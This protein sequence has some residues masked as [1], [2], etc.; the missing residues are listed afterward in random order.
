M[1]GREQKRLETALRKLQDDGIIGRKG[2]PGWGYADRHSEEELK[3]GNRMRAGWFQLWR[4]W[5]VIIPVPDDLYQFYI[6][7]P[8]SPL[9]VQQ[10]LDLPETEVAAASPRC[11]RSR[12][13]KSVCGT[14]SPNR[15]LLT[16][17]T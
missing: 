10:K 6:A 7:E 2:S 14:D 16:P 4:E 1:P 8:E 3:L 9:M 12:S 13:R 11:P 17:W 15:P 5:D